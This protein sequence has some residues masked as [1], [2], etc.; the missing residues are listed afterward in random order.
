[1]ETTIH[2]G[3][4][5]ITDHGFNGTTSDLFHPGHGMTFMIQITAVKLSVTICLAAITLLLL[6]TGKTALSLINYTLP[7]P[8]K[9]LP[10]RVLL[11]RIFVRELLQLYLFHQHL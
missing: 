4:V 6:L 5:W 10:E 8:V 1:M 3:F 2:S 11:H 7:I 9:L